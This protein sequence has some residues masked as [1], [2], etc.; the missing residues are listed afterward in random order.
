MDTMLRGMRPGGN[1]SAEALAGTWERQLMMSQRHRGRSRSP[2][3]SRAAVGMVADPAPGLSA[4]D[5]MAEV[6]GDRIEFLMQGAGW[7]LTTV[8]GRG[9]LTFDRS[10]ART[11]PSPSPLVNS[12]KIA[13]WSIRCW[14][15]AASS[16][17]GSRRPPRARRSS[18]RWRNGRSRSR[19]SGRGADVDRRS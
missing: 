7:I 15:G 4:A 10:Q 19:T 16:S 12:R 3:R 9:R 2:A 14:P 5:V 1:W 6:V 18:S 17:T 13:R 11:P 8:R